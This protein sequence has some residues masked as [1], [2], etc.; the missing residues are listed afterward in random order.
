VEVPVD[1][2]KLLGVALCVGGVLALGLCV[3]CHRKH[4]R[5]RR[6]LARFRRNTVGSSRR[7]LSTGGSS[8]RQHVCDE[9]GERFASVDSV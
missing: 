4:R 9:L 6:Q 2:F 7:Q 8:R 1:P 5:R 3:W